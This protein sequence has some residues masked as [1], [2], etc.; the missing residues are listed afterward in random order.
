MNVCRMVGL[1]LTLASC[2]RATICPPVYAECSP[3]PTT[4][5][6]CAYWITNGLN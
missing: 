4:A 2:C 3:K 1:P 6:E 5:P